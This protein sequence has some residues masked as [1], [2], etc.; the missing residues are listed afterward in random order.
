[1]ATTVQVTYADGE[2]E[3]NVVPA[4]TAVEMFASFQRE[5]DHPDRAAE[6]RAVLIT[7]V[8]MCG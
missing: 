8:T 4:S 7:K 6:V 2:V 3:D 5:V 1:M